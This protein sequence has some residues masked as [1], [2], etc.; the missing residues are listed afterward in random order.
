MS[1]I[2]S[3]GVTCQ[4]PRLN[5]DFNIWSLVRGSLPLRVGYSTR[6]HQ[7]SSNDRPRKYINMLSVNTFTSPYNIIIDYL[8]K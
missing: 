3:A 2:G 4:T 8:W 7:G 1:V 6:H 5:N